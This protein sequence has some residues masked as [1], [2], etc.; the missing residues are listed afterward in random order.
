M[1]KSEGKTVSLYSCGNLHHAYITFRRELYDYV[2]QDEKDLFSKVTQRQEGED[3]KFVRDILKFFG[4]A[5]RTMGWL[6][7]KLVG[8]NN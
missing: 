5:D 2:Q 8:Y 6:D 4:R 7:L 1:T 3:S